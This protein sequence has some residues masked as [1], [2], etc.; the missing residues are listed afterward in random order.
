[1]DA[2]SDPH[3]RLTPRQDNF[4]REYLVDFN[5]A[6]AAIRAG[7]SHNGADVQASRLLGLAKVQ[8]AV[9]EVR[10]KIAAQA[11]LNSGYVLRNL[12]REAEED[13]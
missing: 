8:S 13:G 5:G 9:E 12:K 2:L 10:Q 3:K 7:Y 1:M 11:E 4:A 6:Q